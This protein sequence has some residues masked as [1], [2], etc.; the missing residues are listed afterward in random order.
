MAEPRRSADLMVDL[1]L[2]DSILLQQVLQ[3]PEP[4]LRRLAD[5]ATK[6]L[7]PPAFVTD[8]T[9]YRIVVS[10]LGFVAILAI[11]G[12]IYIT[13]TTASGTLPAIPDVLTALGAAA[14]GA[15]AGLLAPSPARA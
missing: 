15:L 5:L 12:A 14:I 3:D 7:P 13:V 6:E 9:T 2:G 8:V 11:G 4:T 1:I 10:M